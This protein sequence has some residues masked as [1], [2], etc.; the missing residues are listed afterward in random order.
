MA[1]LLD[2]LQGLG[3]AALKGLRAVVD[4]GVLVGGRANLKKIIQ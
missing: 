4:A 2:E 3:K 1:F